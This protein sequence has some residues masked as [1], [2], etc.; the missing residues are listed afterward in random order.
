ME[1]QIAQTDT[2]VA[3]SIIDNA[4]AVAAAQEAE[5]ERRA[6]ALQ[7]YTDAATNMF[8]KIETKSEIS[9]SQMIANLQH[10]QEALQQWSEN[11]VTLA[12]RGLDQGLLQQLRD[13]GPE[14]AATVAELVRASDTQLSELSEVFANGSEA[15][16]KALMT[17]L[18]L[19]EVTNSGSDMVDDIAA[20]VD[21]N[22]S[23]EDSTV[24]LIK[25]TKTAAENQV[26]ASNF[27]TIGTQ[28]IN[29]A[30]SGV[31]NARSSLVTAMSEAAAAAYDAARRRLEINSP[32]RLFERMIGLMTMAGWTK[33]VKR[34]KQGL[35]K[36][37]KEN[38]E[39]AIDA[40][41]G[42]ISFGERVSQN[43]AMLRQGVQN[44]QLRL[45]SAGVAASGMYVSGGGNTINRYFHQ[46]INSHEALSPAEMT[47]EAVAAMKRE[48]W[49]L[50]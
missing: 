45:A 32:S 15:A 36:Q 41:G 4:E 19:P 29:G 21:K 37:M 39:A 9:V 12:E 18:G 46:T 17:E 25:D 11:L 14:S 2:A 23:L 20:G 42:V 22:P 49:R 6:N 5:M 28:M 50:P 13:A 30:V 27:S 3:Q 40:A 8:D 44:N 35:V 1:A 7:S 43:M 24:Q 31:V 26:K 10:N 47:T 16:T 34:G 38:V 48:D 33:G